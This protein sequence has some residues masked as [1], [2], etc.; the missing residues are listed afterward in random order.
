MADRSAARRYARAFIELAKDA[1]KVDDLGTELASM[2][3]ACAM[4]DGMLMTVLA[5]PSF[6]KA[7]RKECPAAVMKSMRAVRHHS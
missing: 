3:D 7:E 5:N 2:R 4:E 6:S 1:N